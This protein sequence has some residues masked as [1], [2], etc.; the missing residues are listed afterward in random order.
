MDK[1]TEFVKDIDVIAAY[2]VGSYNYEHNDDSDIDMLVIV[3]E[4]S[5]ELIKKLEK[6]S[7]NIKLANQRKV[8]I[9]VHTIDEYIDTAKFNKGTLIGDSSVIDKYGPFLPSYVMYYHKNTRKLLKGKDILADIELNVN[10]KEDAEPLFEIAQLE[11]ARSPPKAVLLGALAY[12][13]FR[14]GELVEVKDQ[15]LYK[16]ITDIAD[17]FFKGNCLKLIKNSY[18]HKIGKE[19]LVSELDINHFFDKIRT[20]MD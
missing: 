12:M 5:P 4:I 6:I 17:K 1:V 9:W 11:V 2:V 19:E 10:V 18:L 13:L 16:S 8:Q 14:D 7:K 15:R 3:D 20:K